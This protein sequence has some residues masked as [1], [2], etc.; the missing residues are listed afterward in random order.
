ML[1]CN[2]HIHTH[3]TKINRHTSIT[4]TKDVNKYKTI[5]ITVRTISTTKH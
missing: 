2:P 3:M 1:I 5:Q 4:K